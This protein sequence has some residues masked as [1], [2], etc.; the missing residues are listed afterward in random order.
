[1]LCE[2]I[3]NELIPDIDL[4]STFDTWLYTIILQLYG[5]LIILIYDVVTDLTSLI[6]EEVSGPEHLC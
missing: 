6:F 4:A 2:P 5:D 3:I 1:M